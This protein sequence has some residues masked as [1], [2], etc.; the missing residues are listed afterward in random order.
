MTPTVILISYH[1][2]G[3]KGRNRST[4]ERRLIDN[5]LHATKG[6]GLSRARKRAGR[7]VVSIPEGVDAN[8]V[9][10][11]ISKLAGVAHVQIAY[12]IERDTDLMNETALRVLQE[13]AKRRRVKTFRVS[14]RRSNTDFPKNSQE[15]ARDIGGYLFHNSNLAVDLTNFDVEVMVILVEQSTFISATRIEGIGGLPA[16]SSGKVV[17]L[18]SSGIDSPVATWRILRRGGIGIGVHFSGRPQTASTSEKLVEEIGEVL[19]K[20]GGMAR[21][22][23][24]PFGDIQKD[25]AMS[26]QPSLRVIMYRRVMI[27]IAEKIAAIEGAQAI[28]T[29]ESLGQVASQTLR[30]IAAVDE[31]ATLPMLRPLIGSDKL[32][33][34]DDARKI[35]TYKLSIQDAADCCTLFMPRSPETQA[36]LDI[37][38]EQYDALDVDDFI[39][40][41]LDEMHYVNY[42]CAVYRRPRVLK[43]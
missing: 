39:R 14:A 13:E 32:E 11:D 23:I 7:F 28:V 6:Y 40:R 24:V 41:A 31:V 22:Y 43:S 4:F 36:K 27:A 21:T 38:K 20:T 25:I 30:N 34:I 9:A 26:V 12:S 3:L 18:L 29:G 5:I 10:L 19:A 1:E 37:V 2:L 35:G 8:Q 17:S 33:I 16:G 42:P 15:I